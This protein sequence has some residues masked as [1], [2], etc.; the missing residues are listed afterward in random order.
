MMNKFLEKFS[1]ILHRN[2]RPPK[3]GVKIIK[4]YFQVGLDKLD[5]IYK[6]NQLICAFI[7]A[8]VT[9]RRENESLFRT[10]HR[11]WTNMLHDTLIKA[12]VLSGQHQL[13]LKEENIVE[14]I[15]II[16]RF[17]LNDR[18]LFIQ[19]QSE[20]NGKKLLIVFPFFLTKNFDEFYR[21]LF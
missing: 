13:Q 14:Q 18:Q 9:Y 5:L 20:V 12:A 15:F 16:S 6:T 3:N 21:F 7:N 4:I 19:R 2:P 8:A 1:A 17:V 11:F 10:K